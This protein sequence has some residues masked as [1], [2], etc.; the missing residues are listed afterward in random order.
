MSTIEVGH[1]GL[2]FVP[3]LRTQDVCFVLAIRKSSNR[4]VEYEYLCAHRYDIEWRTKV[5]PIGTRDPTLV[6]LCQPHPT[7][8]YYEFLPKHWVMPDFPGNPM[9]CGWHYS[10]PSYGKPSCSTHNP[11]TAKSYFSNTK[12]TTT[13]TAP[14]NNYSTAQTGIEP[15]PELTGLAKLLNP[16]AKVGKTYFWL[17]DSSPREGGAKY[18]LYTLSIYCAAMSWE[19]MYAS[20]PVALGMRDKAANV[21]FLPK[22]G[23]NDGA[24]LSNLVNPMELVNTVTN[25]FPALSPVKPIAVKKTS[26]QALFDPTFWI[27]GV[28][29]LGIATYQAKAV[30]SLSIAARKRRL[31]AVSSYKAPKLDPNSLAIAKVRKKEF[32]NAG[33]GNYLVNGLMIAGSYGIEAVS[34]AASIA[35][36]SSNGFAVFINGLGSIAGAETFYNATLEPDEK[37]A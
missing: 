17:T 37:K 25:A 1:Y 24:T 3:E 28:L 5:D 19:S 4:L 21:K 26:P 15:E 8:V 16:I 2:C 11:M 34:F 9:E 13:T 33:M 10:G 31:D 30:R 18:I 27:A 32:E 29:S 22:V 7:N 6:E 20:F 35:G 23:I 14:V 36:G 12:K